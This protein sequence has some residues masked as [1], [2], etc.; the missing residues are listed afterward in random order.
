MKNKSLNL[1]SFISKIGDFE[2][3]ILNYIVADGSIEFGKESRLCFLL[4]F[5][6]QEEKAQKRFDIIDRRNYKKWARKNKGL[7]FT[8]YLEHV[9]L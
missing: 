8:N 5:L 1:N 7:S 3:F 9:K 2:F 4:G 6:G